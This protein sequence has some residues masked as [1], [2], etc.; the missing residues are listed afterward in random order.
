MSLSSTYWNSVKL[1]TK[2]QRIQANLVSLHFTLLHFADTAF[3]TD[4]RLWQLCI[5]PIDTIFPNI[6]C[7]LHAPASLFG[8]SHNISNFFHYYICYSDPW[9][10]KAQ[11]MVSIFSNKVLLIKVCTFFRHNFYIHK[12]NKKY[13]LICFTVILAL[14][15]W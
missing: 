1:F 13:H 4:W 9:S 5:K 14:L 15:Q 12:E 8:N 3:L 10:L 11:M 7:L 6:I 2:Y